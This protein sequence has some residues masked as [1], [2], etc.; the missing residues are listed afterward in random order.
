MWRSNY[1]VSC[2]TGYTRQV[3]SFR[4]MTMS[5]SREVKCKR[6]LYLIAL[7]AVLHSP[8]EKFFSQ[9]KLICCFIQ[10]VRWSWFI[11]DWSVLNVAL[12]K[13]E[14]K[15]SLNEYHIEPYCFHSII[16]RV[17]WYSCCSDLW[18]TQ[19]LVVVSF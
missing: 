2:C 3:V 14:C 5:K 11:V 1:S 4:E 6:F 9:Y 10:T 7:R 15:K 16:V 13:R 19:I 17:F 18:N 12:L 8:L